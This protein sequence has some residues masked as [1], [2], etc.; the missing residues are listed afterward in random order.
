MLQYKLVIFL[1]ALPGPPKL[2]GQCSPGVASGS[3]LSLHEGQNDLSFF[4]SELF[5]PSCKIQE[6]C[7]V[8][9]ITRQA[10]T[11]HSL[12]QPQSNNIDPLKMVIFQGERKYF[13][14][15]L[16][17]FR[18]EIH[19]FQQGFQVLFNAFIIFRVEF[20]FLM[21]CYHYQQ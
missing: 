12:G 14:Y 9:H 3:S 13:L 8:G 7:S 19:T 5:L 1:D 18:R 15:S 11:L 6:P 21:E 2:S 16:I 10:D 17:L 20:S 4:R